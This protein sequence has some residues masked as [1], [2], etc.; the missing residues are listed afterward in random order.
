MISWIQTVLQKHYKWLF[1]I[2]LFIII[3]SFV[4]TVGAPGISGFKKHKPIFYGFDLS[5][6]KDVLNLNQGCQL[7]YFL[8]TGGQLESPEKI[9]EAILIRAL[10]LGIAKTL[11]IP[12]P[13][14][15]ELVE[16]I[17]SYPVF[18]DENGEFNAD[19]YQAFIKQIQTDSDIGEALARELI[20]QS[21]QADQVSKLLSNPALILPQEAML[22][23]QAI[24]TKWELQTLY[25]DYEKFE[26]TIAPSTEDLEAYY[27]KHKAAYSHAES[28][29]A[30]RTI[31]L[32]DYIK[33][34]KE[35]QFKDAV[36]QLAQQ[37]QEH[38]E[39]VH[40]FQ[41]ASA[42]NLHLQHKTYPIFTFQNPPAEL[43]QYVLKV[44]KN[45]KTNTITPC[46]LP[47]GAYLLYVKSKTIPKLA[48]TDPIIT[49]V[50]EELKLMNSTF[51][52]QELLKEL[53]EA[54]LP[55]GS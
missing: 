41:K 29:E 19:S 54:Q 53:I 47:E 6:Q 25:C 1:S 30:A 39:T 51:G 55:T 11:Y 27:N 23:A 20:A 9:Q 26:T 45:L 21:F 35:K 32:E 28:F 22:L 33:Q 44:L 52:M 3:I 5:S 12:G 34:E 13:T 50:I 43:D 10:L 18:K 2:L 7:D 38:E 36:I 37:L 31:V 49:Q 24:Q 40:D 8:N 42:K 16:W 48:P 14:E 17:K 15:T 4:F 46:F